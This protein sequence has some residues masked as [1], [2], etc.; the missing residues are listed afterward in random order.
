MIPIGIGTVDSRCWILEFNDLEFNN[1]YADFVRA[2]I[3]NGVWRK[4]RHPLRVGNK[5]Q[6][7]RLAAIEQNT[8]TLI[9]PDE[10]TAALHICE[11][12]PAMG[13]Q[14]DQIACGDRGLKHTYAVIF[15]QEGV[16]LRRGYQRV[17]RIRPRPAF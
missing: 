14:R 2:K 17:E 3:F 5:R 10:V 16:M 8:A 11:T 15:E 9:P 1:Q 6:F 12:T 13:M 7:S 4:R